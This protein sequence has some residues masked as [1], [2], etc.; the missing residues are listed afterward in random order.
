VLRTII[1][2]GEIFTGELFGQ[3]ILRRKMTSGKKLIPCGGKNISKGLSKFGI[4]MRR[5]LRFTNFKILS[6]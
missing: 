3:I 1:F 4:F 5:P 2:V 6:V